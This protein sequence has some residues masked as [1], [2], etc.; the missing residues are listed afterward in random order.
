MKPNDQLYKIAN[1]AHDVSA[2]YI[3]TAHYI[4]EIEASI[5]PGSSIFTDDMIQQGRIQAM[6]RYI[7]Q[8]LGL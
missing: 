4:N 2:N 8:Q 6:N 1:N 7:E 3:V 5:S